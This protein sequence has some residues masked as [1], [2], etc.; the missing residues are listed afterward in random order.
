MKPKRARHAGPKHCHAKQ[1]HA[2]KKLSPGRPPTIQRA[3]AM[4]GQNI[5]MQKI[6]KQNQDTSKKECLE[7]LWKL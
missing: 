6:P 7:Q 1:R 2:T 4:Q 5:A 3:L